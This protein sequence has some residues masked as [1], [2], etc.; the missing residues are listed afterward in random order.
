MPS[1]TKVRQS[2]LERF[3]ECAV[4]VFLEL[5]RRKNSPPSCAGVLRALQQSPTGERLRVTEVVLRGLKPSSVLKRIQRKTDHIRRLYA[6]IEH[7]VPPGLVSLVRMELGDR[8]IA[9]LESDY[10]LELRTRALIGF[11]KDSNRPISPQAW[12]DRGRQTETRGTRSRSEAE[13]LYHPADP[14]IARVLARLG[15]IPPVAVDD[16]LEL[17]LALLR[18]VSMD[19]RW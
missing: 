5:A 11:A 19:L 16:E 12:R 2:V 17:R 6:E 13:C 1:R 8:G 15:Y 10:V 9:C 7:T 18:T 4:A 14:T 3:D